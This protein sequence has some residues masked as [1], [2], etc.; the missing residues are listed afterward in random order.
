MT[1]KGKIDLWKERCSIQCSCAERDIVIYYCNELQCPNHGDPLYCTQCAVEGEKHD[2]KKP[3]LIID[4]I[5]KIDKDWNSLKERFS[6][7]LTQADSRY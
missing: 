2:H 4:E 1:M 5:M 7:I 6:E 3:P